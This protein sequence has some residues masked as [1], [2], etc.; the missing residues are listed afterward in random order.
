MANVL[1]GVTGSVAALKT[2]ELFGELK[3]RGHAVRV[4]ATRAATYFFDPAAIEPRD[5]KR[6][7]SVVSLDEDEWPGERYGRGDEVLHIEL[8]RWAEVLVIAPLDANTLAKLAGGI[9]DNCLTCIWRAWDAARPVV[10]APA[11]NTMMWE[12]P[13]TRRHLRALATDFGPD[14]LAADLDQD[15]IIPVLND[16]C[17]SLHMVAPVRKALA[18]GDVGQGGLATPSAIVDAVELALRDGTR[19]C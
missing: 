17:R 10:L 4:V 11:M 1:L 16:R 18:C 12:H 19:S 13:L 9:C 7:R 8:R 6:N 15:A 5:G 2:P 14:D 3:R